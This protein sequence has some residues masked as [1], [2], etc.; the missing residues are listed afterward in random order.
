MNIVFFDLETTTNK[1]QT[2]GIVQLAAVFL[3]PDGPPQ[4]LRPQI[5]FNSLA[6]PRREISKE[7]SAVHGITIEHLTYAPPERAVA[8]TFFCL[9]HA[10]RRQGPLVLSGYNIRRF[11]VPILR[12]AAR[13]ELPMNIPVFDLFELVQRDPQLHKSGLKLGEVYSQVTGKPPIDAH[14]AAAD[15]LMCAE[16]LSV[17]VQ[18]MT[19]QTFQQLFQDSTEPQLLK[20]FP[21]GKHKGV[22]IDKVPQSYLEWCHENLNDCSIDLRYTIEVR[23]GLRPVRQ[24]IAAPKV[25]DNVS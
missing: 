10:L 17:Y 12:R 21:F 1:P 16:I 13:R 11:D 18:W 5:V 9:L 3:N 22:P 19:D 20:A 24:G 15:V 14:D 6:R 2:A 25:V 23:L 4:G 8:Q 7:A